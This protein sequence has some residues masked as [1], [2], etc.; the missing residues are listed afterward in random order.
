MK[1][2]IK[3]KMADQSFNNWKLKYI[4]INLSGLIQEIL[5]KDRI[6]LVFLLN[7]FIPKIMIKIPI[8][9]FIQN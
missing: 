2:K 4:G 5:S 7:N 8:G 9:L 1:N 6:I 3:I